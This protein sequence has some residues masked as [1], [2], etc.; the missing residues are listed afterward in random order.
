MPYSVKNISEILSGELIGSGESIVKYL[1]TD[2]RTLISPARSLFFALVGQRFDGHNFIT[3]LYNKGLRNFVVNK[4]PKD[5]DNLNDAS[6]IVVTDT[7]SALQELSAHHR[8]QFEI[9]IIGITGSNGKTVVKE[10]LFQLLH[11]D[12]NITRSPKSYN[13]QVG[14]PLSVWLLDNKS[15]LGVFEAGISKIDE[16]RHLQKII[17]PDIGIFTNISDAHQENFID[18]KHKIKEKLK[19]F[20]DVKTLVYCKDYQLLET[21]LKSTDDFEDVNFFSWSMKY[22]ADLYISKL[23]ST[24]NETQITGKYLNNEISITIPFTDAGSIE[25]AIHCWAVMLYFEYTDE[26]IN[27]RMSKLCPVAM[28]LE[29]K[30]GINN[31]VIINDSYNSDIGSLNIAL[32]YLNRINKYTNKTLVL[33]EILQSNNNEQALYQEVA[34]LINKKKIHRLIGVGSAMIKHA[35]LFKIKKHFFKTTED[36]IKNLPG[37]KIMNEA[38]LLKGA[39]KFKFEKISTV[40]QHK[41]HETVLEVN[42]NA[43]ADNLNLYR[44]KLKP[45]TKIMGMVKAF[46]YGSGIYEIANLLQ[47]NNVDYL[48]VAYV[49]EGVELRKAG[50]SLPIMV[51]NPEINSFEVML[52]HYLE[53][54]IYSFRTLEAFMQ[55]LQDSSLKNF[56]IHIELDTGMKRLG[57]EEDELGKLITILLNDD[58]II[59]KSVFSHLVAADDSYHDAF[60]KEQ[61]NKFN[62]LSKSIVEKFDY[63]IIRHICNSAGIQNYPEAHFDMVR[64]GIG[65]YGVGDD[66]KLR[67]VSTLKSIVSQIRTIKPEES[68]GY[69]RAEMPGREMKIAVIPIGYADGLSRSLSRG[70]GQVFIKGKKA[71]IVGNVCMDMCM[72]DIT[73]INVNEGDEVVIFGEV[74]SLE[75][76]AKDLDTIPY[77]V[78]TNVSRRVKRVYYQE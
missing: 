23:E 73:G 22:P 26:L 41:V 39:R 74:Y 43:I 60:T 15:E 32:D 71:P 59:I 66:S 61:I 8:K 38:V 6:F 3:D 42:L 16:M 48:A 77:E 9:P 58:K 72:V 29:Q 31:C 4:V 1:L 64:L 24:D 14:V 40:L 65:L 47:F 63:P 21:Q 78:L 55:V 25:N 53:P 35:D 20:T 49:D 62:R 45:G 70:R 57:F 18:Y 75:K 36:L 27:N 10:W 67:N 44:S 56:P 34:E 33:S 13:S 28:R 76:I 19:L 51:M 68:I 2:S 12:K 7:L 30:E 17:N 50:I 52:E 46:S 5:S 69:A 11:Q 37:L 54:E